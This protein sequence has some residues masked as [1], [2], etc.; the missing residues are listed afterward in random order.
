V[1]Q[2]AFPATNRVAN[3]YDLLI[4]DPH[5]GDHGAGTLTTSRSGIIGRC[6]GRLCVVASS[7]RTTSGVISVVHHHNKYITPGPCVFRAFWRTPMCV[8]SPTAS[9]TT[10]TV[11]CALILRLW[12]GRCAVSHSETPARVP[13]HR[14]GVSRSPLKT[15]YKFPLA[16][17]TGGAGGR[18]L[19][20]PLT[21]NNGRQG[22]L[23]R[24][25]L[26]CPQ[27]P[28]LRRG[29]RGLVIHLLG[30]QHYVRPRRSILK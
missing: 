25:L 12:A 7:G 24:H 13:F 26:R 28:F 21:S 15:P 19:C 16:K 30:V 3:L 23:S 11:T 27:L 22:K 18:C 1:T 6:V 14:T 4:G 5:G 29:R 8:H 10:V 17:C 20:D 2:Q 9:I